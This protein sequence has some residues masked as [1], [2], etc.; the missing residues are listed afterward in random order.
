M[1]NKIMPSI[2]KEITITEYQ[3]FVREVYGLNNDRYFNTDGMLT[4]IQRFAMRALKGVRKNDQE[5]IK[6]NLIISLSWYISLL[7]QF[8]IKLEEEIWKKFPYFCS[9]CAVCPCSCLKNR[10]NQRQKIAI[11]QSKKPKTLAEFQTMF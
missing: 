8:H 7:N 5:K 3:D 9:Y 2:K 1:Y 11:D 10:P 6:N 4:Q